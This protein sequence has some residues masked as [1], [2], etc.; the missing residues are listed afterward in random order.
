MGK[1][2]CN[3]M[4]FIYGI[5]LMGYVR[6][7]M[8]KFRFRHSLSWTWDHDDA[9]WIPLSY[10]IVPQELGPLGASINKMYIWCQYIY[11]IFGGLILFHSRTS[12]GGAEE[13]AMALIDLNDRICAKSHLC[14]FPMYDILLRITTSACLF[15]CLNLNWCRV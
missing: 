1:L 9:L 12:F 11:S 10:F 15:P 2:I 5:F 7:F 3:G 6:N 8:R 13:W 14:C 4:R